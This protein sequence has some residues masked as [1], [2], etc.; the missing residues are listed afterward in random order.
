MSEVHRSD[1]KSS[2]LDIKKEIKVPSFLQERQEKLSKVC[3]A[4]NKKA[5]FS[6]Q[7]LERPEST[8]EFMNK[9]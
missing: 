2:T 1:L 7:G 9:F 6:S 8:K 5:P 4:S 3:D